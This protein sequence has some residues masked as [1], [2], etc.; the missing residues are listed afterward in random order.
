MTR[1]AQWDGISVGLAETLVSD[2]DSVLAAEP[3]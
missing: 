3:T 1:D 2:A